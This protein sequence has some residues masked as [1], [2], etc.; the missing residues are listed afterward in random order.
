M[1]AIGKGIMISRNIPATGYSIYVFDSIGKGLR[2]INRRGQGP[3]EYTSIAGLVA[4][5]E[6]NNEIFVNFSLGK[7][8]LVYDLLGNFKRS[9]AFQGDVSSRYD[10]VAIFDRAN[11]ICHVRDTY[12]DSKIDAY[13]QTEGSLFWILSKQDGSVTE[14]IQIPYEKRIDTRFV[15]P[16]GRGGTIDVWNSIPYND[17]WLLL[18]PSS[19]TIYKVLPDYS[20]TPF[21]AR[22]PSIQS[23]NPE[24][25][26][27]PGV[28]T[29]HYYFMRVII[30]KDYDPDTNSFPAIDLMYDRQKKAIFEYVVYNDDFLTKRPVSMWNRLPDITLINNEEIA[31]TERLE[32]YQIV[33]AYKNGQLKG[34]LKEIAAELDE[35]D[36]PVI[37]IARNKK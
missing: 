24:R 36:N 23:M 5:D 35:E 14:E 27:F 11:L 31:F 25:F 13:T 34:K 3:G 33:E 17:S 30:K 4:L 20:I 19:D 15:D 29:D 32:A 21:I 22:T 7:K 6:Y 1:Q 9:I 8:I 12:F 10:F 28:L 16:N 2:T 37:M 26:L 18:E